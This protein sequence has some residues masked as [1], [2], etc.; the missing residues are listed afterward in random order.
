MGA[1]ILRFPEDFLWGTVCSP[2]RYEEQPELLELPG[3]TAHLLSIEWSCLE[4]ER[5]AWAGDAE[6][7]YRTVLRSSKNRG[8]TPSVKLHN[9]KPPSWLE[10]LGGWESERAAEA[11]ESHVGRAVRSFGADVQHWIT[12]DA[13]LSSAYSAYSGSVPSSTR[14]LRRALRVYRNMIRA[15][16]RAYHAIH[17]EAKKLG[18]VVQVGVAENVRIFEPLRKDSLL[19]RFAAGLRDAF[20]NWHLLDSLHAGVIVYPFGFNKYLPEMEGCFDFIEVNYLGPQTVRF[21]PGRAHAFFGESTPSAESSTGSGSGCD[22]RG[23]GLGG[24]L[25]S[26]SRFGKPIYITENSTAEDSPDERCRLIVSHL[27]QVYDAIEMGCDVRGY[28]LCL[29]KDDADAGGQLYRRICAEN[30]LPGDIVR[31][32]CP[33]AVW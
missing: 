10:E 8:I 29:S 7:S 26:V 21:R 18:V 23:E 28:S 9:R 3:I 4:P 33:D 25:A 30:G 12:A 20:L 17:Q 15:H 16:A 13:P 2:S 6:E 1:E 5:G 32:Y 14:N 22:L 19:D 24:I 31:R 11:F 27:K